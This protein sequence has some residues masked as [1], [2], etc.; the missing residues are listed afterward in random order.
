MSRRNC[1]AVFA[2]RQRRIGG[3]VPLAQFQVDVDRVG[4]FLAALHRV[5]VI[6]KGL[7]H[8]FRRAQKVFIAVHAHAAGVGPELARV[9]AQHDILRF[10]IFAIGV[11]SVAC[12]RPAAIPTCRQS[13]REP[14]IAIRW[15]S[16]P[17]F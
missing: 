13:A 4:D 17:L 14:S 3:K 9:D 1:S 10:G 15:I 6:R 5:R 12:A 2:V 7:V 11:M 16:T 8:L